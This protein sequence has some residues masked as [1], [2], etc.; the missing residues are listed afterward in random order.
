[1]ILCILYPNADSEQSQRS[2]MDHLPNVVNGFYYFCKKLHLMFDWVLNTSLVAVDA[3]KQLLRM[4]I[5]EKI[6]LHSHYV[7]G[8]VQDIL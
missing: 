7:T 4:H 1:M 3:F 8:K 6:P 2:K 5:V